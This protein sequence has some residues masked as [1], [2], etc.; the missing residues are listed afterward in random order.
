MT[1]AALVPLD[2]NADVVS[3]IG[4]VEARLQGPR[5]LLEAV[6]EDFRGLMGSQF[7]SEGQFLLGSAWAPLADATLDAK[8]RAGLDLRILHATLRLRSSLESRTGETVEDIRY[9]EAVFGTSVPY[10]RYHQRSRGAPLPQRQMVAI[11]GADRRRWRDGVHH[12]LM[13]GDTSAVR[14]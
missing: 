14:R 8:V 10:A 2:G 7:D 6:G 3:R 11:R 9:T 13:T 4:D 5:P 12:W 1:I